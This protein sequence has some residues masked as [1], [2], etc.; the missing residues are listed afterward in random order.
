MLFTSAWHAVRRGEF[1][2]L[3]RLSVMNVSASLFEPPFAS[4]SAYAHIDSSCSG[5]AENACRYACWES[6]FIPRRSLTTPRPYAGAAD[7]GARSEASLKY[8]FAPW[9][10]PESQAC[11]PL[12]YALFAAPVRPDV[13]DGSRTPTWPP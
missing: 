7:F 11:Q 9:R 10:S 12:S 6:D 2:F 8:F 3:P 4:E 1:G 13:P 5:S